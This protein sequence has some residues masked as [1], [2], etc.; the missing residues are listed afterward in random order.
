VQHIDRR[1]IAT[2][3]DAALRGLG[4][5]ESLSLAV[6]AKWHYAWIGLDIE[7]FFPAG[8]VAQDS[9]YAQNTTSIRNEFQATDECQIPQ[10]KSS[11]N[12]YMRH[13]LKLSETGL[14]QSLRPGE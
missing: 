4:D 5:L 8:A 7:I 13:W 14:R 9:T 12:N 1:M 6:S 3:L 2:Q 11:F 10:E